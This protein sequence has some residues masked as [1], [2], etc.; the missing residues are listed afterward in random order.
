MS[1]FGIPFLVKM[2]SMQR[3]CRPA[4][5]Y[6]YNLAITSV[7]FSE[8]KTYKSIMTFNTDV[9]NLVASIRMF[10][11]K[12]LYRSRLSRLTGIGSVH[13]TMTVRCNTGQ[14]GTTK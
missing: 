13:G 7:S 10:V 3:N 12:V 1:L 14:S 4:G 8:G 9:A 2:G 5:F 11:S 6:Y